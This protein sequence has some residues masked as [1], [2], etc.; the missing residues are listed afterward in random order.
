MVTLMRCTAFTSCVAVA[1]PSRAMAKLLGQRDVVPSIKRR[2]ITLTKSRAQMNRTQ[3]QLQLEY[4]GSPAV[5]GDSAGRAGL[6]PWDA[7]QALEVLWELIG[8]SCWGGPGY[9]APLN[10]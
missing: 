8:L 6:E 9:T 4:R 10:G 3:E 7:A 1:C 2:S 5:G